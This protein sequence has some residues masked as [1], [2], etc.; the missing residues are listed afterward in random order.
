MMRAVR[1]V[2]LIVAV[3]GLL[4]LAGGLLAIL[5]SYAAG[6]EQG[7]E[8]WFLAII[9][10]TAFFPLAGTAMVA[11]LISAC[12][13][14]HRSWWFSGAVGGG[15][16]LGLLFVAGILRP[17]TEVAGFLYWIVGSILLGAAAAALLA[18]SNNWFDQRRGGRV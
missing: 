14:R 8:L 3:A 18:L 13:D 12:L 10:A 11:R 2:L 6:V 17:R 4:P 7:Y 15:L 5:V 9:V 1:E 16:M